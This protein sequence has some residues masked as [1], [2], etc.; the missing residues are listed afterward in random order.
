MLKKVIAVTL[1]T[2]AVALSGAT[3]CGAQQKQGYRKYP[4]SFM[5]AGGQ[6]HF[7]LGTGDW[8]DSASWGVG[9]TGFF[10]GSMDAFVDDLSLRG[11]VAHFSLDADRT[12]ATETVLMGSAVYDVGPVYLLGGLGIYRGKFETRV[13]GPP[14]FG[15]TID[16]VERDLGIHLGAGSEFPISDVLGIRVE[17]QLHHIW[18]PGLANLTDNLIFASGG[19]AYHF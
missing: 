16:T 17:G 14:P 18:H 2:V 5:A 10:E 6:L 3:V 9:L 8:A 15:K 4:S 19:L 7:G 11:T 12:D 1:A 13:D